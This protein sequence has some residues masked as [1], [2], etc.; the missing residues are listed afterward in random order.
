MQKVRC[1]V[2]EHNLELTNLDKVF[3]PEDCYTKADLLDYYAQAAPWLLP[4]LC[5]RPMV[6]SRYPDGIAGKTFYQKDCPDYAPDWLPTVPVYSESTKKVI[7]YCLCSDVDSLLWL[8]NQGCIEMHPWLS[9][10]LTPE[11]PEAAIFDLDP[12]PPADFAD[13]LEIALLVRD[14]LEVFG[15]RCYPKTS[16]ATGLH[17]Y[18]PIERRYNYEQVRQF[19]GWIAAMITKFHPGRATTERAVQR[20]TGRVYLDYLQNSLGKTIASVYSVRPH[21]GAPVSIPL[22]WDEVKLGQIRPE[23]FNMDNAVQSGMERKELFEPVLT[24]RQ[25]LDEILR[26]AKE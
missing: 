20:R 13:V 5:Q 16:G 8:V 9:S 7:N 24:D 14:A 19:T 11:N 3:W 18:V 10:Y 2:N 6:M 17:I 4:H 23:H 25:S 21:T 26:A 1:E 22:T 15:L 12:D